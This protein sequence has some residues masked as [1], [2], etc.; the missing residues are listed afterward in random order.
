[1]TRRL[2]T[3]ALT[4]LAAGAL[5]GCNTTTAVAPDASRVPD[6]TGAPVAVTRLRAEP[7]SFTFSSGLRTPQRTVVRDEAAWR[8]AW[9]AMWQGYSPQ[10]ALPPVDFAREVVVVAALGERMTGGYQ[11]FVDSA[12]TTAGGGVVVH[13]RTEAPGPRCGTTQALTQPVDLARLPRPAGEVTFQDRA[14]VTD[15]P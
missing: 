10:P 1:M 3:P 15:C 7:Y 12:T 8:A 2:L 14:V 9:A 11:I 6:R 13:V 5:A 4:A